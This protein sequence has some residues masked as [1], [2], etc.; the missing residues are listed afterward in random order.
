MLDTRYSILDI[1]LAG[2]YRVDL[3]LVEFQFHNLNFV[4]TN[5][6]SDLD[7]LISFPVS[8]VGEDLPT[9]REGRDDRD[10][11]DSRTYRA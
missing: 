5:I 2:S 3:C 6:G 9:G 10:D 8:D 4:Q 1:F 7:C 11:R